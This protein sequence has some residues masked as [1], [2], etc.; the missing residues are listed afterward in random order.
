MLQINKKDLQEPLKPV[1]ISL[2]EE[3]V[4]MLVDPTPPNEFWIYVAMT[5]WPKRLEE[6]ETFLF[7]NLQES[8]F[9]FRAM[10]N[11]I[12]DFGGGRKKGAE[13]PSLLSWLIAAERNDLSTQGKK[14][15]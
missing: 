4:D 7:C 10:P 13:E 3:L 2:L 5:C 9:F 8:T 12:S 6:N 11:S 14:I 1:E 15:T